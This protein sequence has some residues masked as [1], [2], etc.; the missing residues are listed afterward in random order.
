MFSASCNL[1]NHGNSVYAWRLTYQKLGFQAY[2]G[3][4]SCYINIA[5]CKNR[6]NNV[7]SILEFTESCYFRVSWQ[8]KMSQMSFQTSKGV[9]SCYI[10]ITELKFRDIKVLSNL[11]FM[12]SC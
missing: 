4:H 3:V 8:A 10:G 11:E 9:L 1:R 5:Q 6:E 12:E 7:L 2:N